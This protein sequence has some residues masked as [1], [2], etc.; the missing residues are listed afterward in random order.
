[1]RRQQ[2]QLQQQQQNREEVFCLKSMDKGTRVLGRLLQNMLATILLG[3]LKDA[4]CLQSALVQVLAVACSRQPL[5]GL[6]QH[7]ALH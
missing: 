4:V 7:A 6:T 1:L 3:R 2:T 5:R